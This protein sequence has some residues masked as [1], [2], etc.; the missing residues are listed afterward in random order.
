MRAPI[1]LALATVLASAQ[2][3]DADRAYTAL[4]ARDYDVAVPAFLAAIQAAPTRADIR[5]DLAYTLLKIGEPSLARDQFREAMRLDPADATAALEYAFLCNETKQQ[6]E[7]RRVFD[8][9]RR[10]GNATAD[11]A[12]HNIDDPLA[13]GI[14]RW[15]RAILLGG[16]TFSGH[17]ELATLAEQRDELALAATH[18]EIAWR[19]L[20]DR[21]TVLVDLGRVWL[22]MG[23][24]ADAASAL[25]AASRGGEP[26]AAEMARE[27]LPARYPFVSEF[28]LALALDPGNHELRR[29]L[30]YLFL[31]MGRE[32][33]AEQ[34]RRL[35]ERLVAHYEDNI[36]AKT[37]LFPGFSA[38]AAALR[39][40]GA[41]LALCTNKREGLTRRLLSA[42]GIGSLFDAIAGGDTFPFH[43]PDP[44]HISE[45]VRLAGGELSTAIMVGDSEADVGAA[46]EAGIPVIAAGFGY[47]AV[48]ATELGADAV[49]NHFEE[50]QAL[51]GGL[52]PQPRFRQSLRTS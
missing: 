29:E 31:R 3:R 4:R 15:Q 49:M 39:G 20:P 11:R 45:L 9:L 52:L 13:L 37:Q 32:T 10:D 26:R 50:L 17:F 12:F 22:A 16:D 7:A 19:L 1:L 27:L 48:P 30:G 43:K 25:L 24:T 28:R 33:E 8:R 23:R 14:A 35:S 21:R 51:I 18:F 41:R 38:A 36:A 47:A 42:L 34:L 44:R 40:S 6:A 2:P 46:R 5:K